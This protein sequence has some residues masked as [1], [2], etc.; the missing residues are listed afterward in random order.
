M[1]PHGFS[2]AWGREQAQVEVHLAC[3]PGLHAA[4]LGHPRLTL[5]ESLG[6]LLFLPPHRVLGG[7][8]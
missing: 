2:V 4:Y 1:T 5:E 3:V 6:S 7:I 8:L